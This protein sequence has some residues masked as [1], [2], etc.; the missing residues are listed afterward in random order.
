MALVGLVCVPVLELV[1]DD[2]LEVVGVLVEELLELVVEVDELLV[3]EVLWQ[4]LEASWPTV[5]APW[6]RFCSRVVLTVEGRL[7]TALFS[8][9]AALAAAPH[10]CEPSA[11]EI[12]C[13]WLL[14][15]LL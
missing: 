1:L 2:V 11:T 4:S 3:L 13:S 6:P 8:D 12:D 14:R 15:L 7:A 9:V 5:E 10:W